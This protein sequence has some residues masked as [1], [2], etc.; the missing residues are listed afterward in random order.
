MDE[1]NEISRD[2]DINIGS[3]VFMEVGILCTLLSLHIIP[4]LVLD[5]NGSIGTAS[6]RAN[7]FVLFRDL[8]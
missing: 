6:V 7:F 4:L 3:K 5:V 1:V 2:V 8:A